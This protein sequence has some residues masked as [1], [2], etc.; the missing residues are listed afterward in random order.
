MRQAAEQRSADC[1]SDRPSNQRKANVTMNSNTKR[2][3]VIGV[4]ALALWSGRICFAQEVKDARQ[5]DPYYKVYGGWE[6]RPLQSAKKQGKLIF[7][8]EFSKAGLAREWK[9]DGVAVE[10]KDG[11]ALLSLSPERI[12]AR[13][14]YGV[15]WAKTP[16]VQP[17][18]IEVEFM[19]DARAPHDAN[20]FWGQ[21]TPS[22]ESLGKP[23][24]CYIMG[25]FGWGGRCAGFEGC[26]CGGYGISGVGDPKS[27]TRYLGNWII[28]DKLQW[29]YLDGSLVVHSSTPTP[30]PKSGYLGLSVYQSKV[31]FR[32]L[33]V[34]SLASKSE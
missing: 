10:I 29:L 28:R 11:S 26:Q 1:G 3:A 32:S 19:L 20:V 31:V 2:I 34:Y 24:E 4:F 8:S 15:L 22:S 9:L 27:G 6:L 5:S 16:F 7:Q 13:K 21:D 33:R 30:P 14:E 18:M 17:L 25:Y 12:A 23:Q